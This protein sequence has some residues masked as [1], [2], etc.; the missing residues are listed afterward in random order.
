MRE[1][2]TK[3]WL[4]FVLASAVL[5]LGWRT[6]NRLE[7]ERGFEPGPWKPLHVADVL[8]ILEELPV[9]VPWPRR[10]QSFSN[11]SRVESQLGSD[12]VPAPEPE[13][14]EAVPVPNWIDVNSLDSAGWDALPWI[15]AWTARRIV[16]YRESLG[17]FVDLAQ[18]AEVYH[19]HD[20]AVAMVQNQGRVDFAKVRMIC[21]DTCSWKTMVGH[22][23][24]DRDLAS[25]IERYRTQHPLQTVGDLR[26][27]QALDSVRLA[28]VSSYLTICSPSEEGF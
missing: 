3:D 8:C 19:I 26:D 13:G 7:W 9:R 4:V 28:K 2:R 21:V 6:W 22:P 18:I 23:L 5:A 1:T 14:K 27:A 10:K 17:G 11:Q 12:Q 20:S 16:K 24:I 15:G 25:L